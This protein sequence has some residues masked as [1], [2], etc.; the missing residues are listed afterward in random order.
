M[1]AG[2][3]GYARKELPIAVIVSIALSIDSGACDACGCQGLASIDQNELPGRGA[4]VHARHDL[5]CQRRRRPCAR[6]AAGLEA[7][8]REA[9]RRDGTRAGQIDRSQKDADGAEEKS[10][11]SA[12]NAA[13]CYARTGHKSMAMNLDDVAIAHPEIS[14]KR[15]HEG[16]DREVA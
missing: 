13:Q 7:L 2:L 4:E 12:F 14:E 10:A 3:I 1:L 5:L 15:S 9:E 11:Q 8:D 16:S 6:T